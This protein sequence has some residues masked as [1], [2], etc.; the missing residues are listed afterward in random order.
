MST[1]PVLLIAWRRPQLTLRVL[2]AI[3]HARP[4]SLF[5]ALDG[6]RAGDE[7]ACARVERIARDGVDW[8]CAVSLLQ[9]DENL[10][11]RRAV[12][13][14]IDW[15]FAHVDRGI[16]LEDDTVPNHSFFPYCGELLSRFEG[17]PA[18]GMVSGVNLLGE[19][20][21][22]G[23]DYFF[24]HGGI[25]GWATWRD[26][27]ALAD[28]GM[29]VW[30]DP[31][32]KDRAKRFLGRRDWKVH[33]PLFERTARGHIDTWDYQWSFSRAS[34][35]MLSTIPATNLVTNIGFHASATHTRDDSSPL[36]NL[37]TGRVG[38]PLQHP[39]E[40]RFDRGYQEAVRHVEHPS[41]LRRFV[42]GL[43]RPR[44]LRDGTS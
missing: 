1:P 24:G 15:F 26:R 40:I 21:T 27:W 35:H 28:I 2:D 9:H 19:W 23:A 38:S 37:G 3:R 41:R 22:G 7:E 6:P 25:W 12:S 13:Q 17:D 39:A 42:R 4:D 43:Q 44:G 31:A 14:A 36:A 33:A 30:N 16:I 11:C 18:I 34:H 5:V 10:G 8:P 20:P 29:Q 32:A